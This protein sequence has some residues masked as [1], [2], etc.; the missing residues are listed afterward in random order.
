MEALFLESK[1]QLVSKYSPQGDQPEAIR[2]LVDGIK[3]ERNIKHYS[4]QLEQEKHL[5]FQM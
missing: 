2:K 5:P 4:V 3:V 1:F